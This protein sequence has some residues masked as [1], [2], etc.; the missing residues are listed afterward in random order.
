MEAED[1]RG[2]AA[3]IMAGLMAEGTTTV[4]NTRYIKRGYSRLEEK[5]RLLGGEITEYVQRE[6]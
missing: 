3:L 5:I 2:G 4:G 1:L 6:P